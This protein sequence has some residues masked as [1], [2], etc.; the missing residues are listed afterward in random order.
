MIA[1]PT[2]SLRMTPFLTLLRKYL[3]KL[4]ERFSI[5]KAFL[6]TY[7]KTVCFSSN[8]LGR[9]WKNIIPPVFEQHPRRKE[10]GEDCRVKKLV[11]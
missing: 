8:I 1:F 5:W 11:P 6:N 10:R 7:Y 3:L 2:S 9:H 4:Q